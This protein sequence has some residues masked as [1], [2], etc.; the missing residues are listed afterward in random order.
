[1]SGAKKKV[2]VGQLWLTQVIV[3]FIVVGIL[4]VCGEFLVFKVM[5]EDFDKFTVFGFIATNFFSFI[6]FL[7]AGTLFASR[8]EFTN[9]KVEVQEN[10]K[11]GAKAP[12]ANPLLK[13]LPLGIILAA[14]CTGVVYVLIYQMDWLPSPWTAVLVSLLFVIPYAIIVK[15]NIASDIEGL[16][17]QGPFRGKAVSSKGA[18]IWLNYILPN[19]LFQ[20][21][22]N[23][24]LANRSFSQHMG[25]VPLDALV[26]DFVITFMFV[27]N[28]T[29]LGIIAHTVSD[30]Y[31]G[32]FAYT[33]KARGIHGFLFFVLMLLMGVGVGVVFAVAMKIVGIDEISFLNS[34]LLK[35][36]VV[37]LSVYLAVRLC[38][39]WAGKKFNDAVAKKMAAMQAAA[40]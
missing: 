40:K 5:G 36:F 21:V 25:A 13:T 12:L 38:V 39:G 22:I 4:I 17:A 11:T 14:I 3:N 28:F 16:A 26:I 7:P 29:F 27:C 30:M 2:S 10:E 6:V 31:E 1:M 24:P 15:L 8:L 34:M 20:V 35:L 32:R 19:F 37:F 9:D 33:G 18:H 23:M